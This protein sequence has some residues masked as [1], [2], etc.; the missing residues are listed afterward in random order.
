MRALRQSLFAAAVLLIGLASVVEEFNVLS[1]SLCVL[2]VA[3]AVSSLTNPLMDGLRER[4]DAVQDLL[5]IG[6]F[7]IFADIARSPRLSLTLKSFTV[8]VVPLLLSCV[9]LLLFSSANPLIETWLNAIDLK[10]WLAR[11]QRRAA[12]VL[13]RD[14]VRGLAVHLSEMDSQAAA[15]AMGEARRSP[16]RTNRRANCSAPPR[17]CV[18]CCCSTCCLPCRPLST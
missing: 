6:P 5:L 9:F 1:A 13:E 10:A 12:V 16:R 2:A 8:W 15:R 4:Y 17:S 18:R 14:A 7:R 3:V 11:T